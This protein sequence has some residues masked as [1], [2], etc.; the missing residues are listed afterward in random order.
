M[1][2]ANLIEK[3][4]AKDLDKDELFGN[5]KEQFFVTSNKFQSFEKFKEFLIRSAKLK[6]KSKARISS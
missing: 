3:I 2:S 1:K 5:E 4:S 6:K